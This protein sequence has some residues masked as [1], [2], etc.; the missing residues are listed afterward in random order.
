MIQS[1][2]LLLRKAEKIQIRTDDVRSYSFGNANLVVIRWV[3]RLGESRRAAQIITTIPM[4][5][6]MLKRT[7]NVVKCQLKSSIK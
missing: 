1:A 3:G 2:L 7:K 4:I 5:P 6:K